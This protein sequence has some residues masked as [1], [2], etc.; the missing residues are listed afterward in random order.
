MTWMQERR[1]LQG[2]LF[3]PRS[4]W[5]TMGSLAHLV[6]SSLHFLIT[7]DIVTLTH[8]ECFLMGSVGLSLIKASMVATCEQDNTLVG[9]DLGS[10]MPHRGT[11]C[12][13]ASPLLSVHFLLR[14]ALNYFGL[15]SPPHLL[16]LGKK[17]SHMWKL[18]LLPKISSQ[19]LLFPVIIRKG[20][21]KKLVLAA[22]VNPSQL[23]KFPGW[24]SVLNAARLITAGLF[25]NSYWRPLLTSEEAEN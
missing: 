1:W 14:E 9:K 15:F 18:I 21:C 11:A 22:C 12:W 10:R 3:L 7:R 20:V 2:S 19:C 6:P 25:Q 13:H 8:S 17:V 23:S 24:S 16:C 4:L 5:I